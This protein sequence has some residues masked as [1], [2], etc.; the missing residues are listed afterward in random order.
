MKSTEASFLLSRKEPGHM[1]ELGKHDSIDCP[2]KKR[3]FRCSPA[4]PRK[5]SSGNEDNCSMLYSSPGKRVQVRSECIDQLQKWHSLFDSGAI[6]K[7]N[8]RA[9]FYQTLGSSDS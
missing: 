5:K 2:P 7:M 8:Y 4:S 1:M 6:T 9:L 3:F